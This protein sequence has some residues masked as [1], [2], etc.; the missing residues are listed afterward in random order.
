MGR[1]LFV[2][3]LSFNTTD[4][5]LRE[6]FARFGEIS[7]AKVIMDRD[8]GRSRGFGFVTFN[9]EQAARTAMSEMDGTDFEGRTIKVNEAQ[10]KQGGGGGGFGGRGGGGGGRRDGGGGHG[11]GGRGRY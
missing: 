9:D 2:G 6:G 4:D 11:G 7:E 3:G 5:G 8:T 1:K 10:D